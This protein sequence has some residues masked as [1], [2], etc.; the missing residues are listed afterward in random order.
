MHIK[1]K[2]PWTVLVLPADTDSGLE[3]H[4]SLRYAK[5][6]ILHGA[7]YTQKNSASFCYTQLHHIPAIEDADY[8][9]R[10][11]QLV[12]TENINV[13]FPTDNETTLWL[14]MHRDQ[15][16]A[17]IIAPSL[18]SC[19]SCLNPE[20]LQEILPSSMAI[21]PNEKSLPEHNYE[22]VCFS[23][24]DN[25][26]LYAQAHT[27]DNQP[28][29]VDIPQTFHLAETIS[30]KLKLSGAWFF[31]LQEKSMGGWQ[32][33]TV[34]PGISKTSII[35]HA[36]GCNLPLLSLYHAAGYDLEIP[37]FHHDFTATSLTEIKFIYDHP[38]EALYIDLDG[39]LLMANGVNSELIAL[40]YQCHNRKIPVNLLT[41][42]PGDLNKTLRQTRLDGLFDRVI[43]VQD[44]S[45][46]KANYILE[47]KAVLIDDSFCERQ[48]TEHLLG[49]R[50]FD[51]AMAIACLLD[52]RNELGHE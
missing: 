46:P 49:I 27:S 19:R 26:V 39:S 22:V 14:T 45:H 24:K 41:R 25:K 12:E 32:V 52:S 48:Q 11:K 36:G 16:D 1:T 8:S 6:V 50:C 31:R 10:L 43:H 38:F 29:F 2:P 4:R 21:A 40:I 33:T 47:K 23:R 44:I 42:H 3:I 30:E 28:R 13:L 34:T 35:H 5:E 18:S 9:L 20:S 15:F 37:H 51:P 7:S 17:E